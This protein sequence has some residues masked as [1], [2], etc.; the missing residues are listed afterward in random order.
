MPLP[1]FSTEFSDLVDYTRGH[2]RLAENIVDEAL[3]LQSELP[4]HQDSSQK[5]VSDMI[6]QN[7]RDPQYPRLRWGLIEPLA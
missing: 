6:M 7:C 3:S 4:E 2:E 1:K 5:G